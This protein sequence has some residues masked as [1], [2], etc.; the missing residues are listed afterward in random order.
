MEQTYKDT[1]KSVLKGI[2]IAMILTVVLLLIFSIVLAYTNIGENTITPIII[3]VT[4]ISILVGSSISNM[5]IKKNGMLNGGIVG[6]NLY[7]DTIF[8][9]KFSKLEIWTKCT[10]YNNDCNR[11][12]IRNTWWNHWS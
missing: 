9:F 6:R 5:K 10:K 4:G 12:N 3:T 1:I 7:F 11:N 2:A 8:N